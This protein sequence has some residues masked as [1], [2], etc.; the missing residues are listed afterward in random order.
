MQVFK[1]WLCACRRGRRCSAPSGASRNHWS[2]CN[3]VLV[4]RLH[5]K[6]LAPYTGADY[7]SYLI[8]ALMVNH[9]P[10]MACDEPSG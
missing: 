10:G 5:E 9:E 2:A 4:P 6:T 3:A 1:K 7:P 8:A